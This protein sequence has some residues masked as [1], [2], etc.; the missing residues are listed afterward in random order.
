MSNLLSVEDLSLKDR[1]TSNNVLRN[2]SFNLREK[3]ILGVVGESGSGKTLLSQAIVNWLPEN[4]V[5]SSGEINFL[6]KK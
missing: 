2:I 6:G 3:E 4:L 1:S 5:I